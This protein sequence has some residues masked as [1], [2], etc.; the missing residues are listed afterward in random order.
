M[1][2]SRPLDTAAASLYVWLAGREGLLRATLDRVTATIAL[3][4]ADPS[5]WRAQLH[6]LL[7]CMPQKSLTPLVI[8]DCGP[9]TAAKCVPGTGDSHQTM[10]CNAGPSSFLTKQQ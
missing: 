3:E 1:R 10:P 5:R 2:S 9:L 8:C 4:A 6:S 7:Q